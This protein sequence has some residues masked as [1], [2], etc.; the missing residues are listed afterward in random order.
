MESVSCILLLVDR[1]RLALRGLNKALLLARHFDAA[2]E[3]LLC[4]TGIQEVQPAR[5]AI[6]GEARQYLQALVQTIVTTDVPIHAEAA[7]ASSLAAGIAEQLAR[8]PVQLIV[9]TTQDGALA[10]D[11]RLASGSGV[12]WLLTRGRPW[13]AVPRFAAAV[14]LGDGADGSLVGRIV[15]VL[16]TLAQR[17]GADLEYLFADPAR[18]RGASAAHRR[19]VALRGQDAR[20]LA[21]RLQYCAGVPAETLPRLITQRDFDL[22][23]VG[24]STHPSDAQTSLRAQLLLTARGDGLLV[25]PRFDSGAPGGA[26]LVGSTAVA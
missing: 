16:E 19:L 12:P 14:N 1:G 11:L 7:F 3:L 13:R 2:L 10:A 21:G 22:L 15:A 18:A 20:P 6:L 9:K 5:R 4:E 23:G 17:C 24:V 26:P 25:P 8:T